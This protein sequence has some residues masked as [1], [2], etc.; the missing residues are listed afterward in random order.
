MSRMTAPE[1]LST[2]TVASARPRRARARRAPS[3]AKPPPMRTRR[4]R[5]PC[6]SAPRSSATVGRP[7]AC[8]A[9]Q[10][11]AAPTS[12]A[13]ATRASSSTGTSAAP[14]GCSLSA[15]S[16]RALGHAAA[17]APAAS[18]SAAGHEPDERGGQPVLAPP[19]RRAR[20]RSP[21]ARRSSEAVAARRRDAL[22]ASITPAAAS[23][24]SEKAT[25]SA[26]TTPAAESIS[27]RTPARV[28]KRTS[29]MPVL[30]ARACGQEHVDRLGVMGPDQ[31]LVD[32]E[33]G[34]RLAPQPGAGDVH[35]RGRGQREGDVVGRDGDPG[36]GDR[37]QPPDDQLVA[38]LQAPGARHAALDD[39]LVGA[40]VDVAP[41]DDRIAATPVD[42][43]DRGAIAR[44]AAAL[45]EDPVDLGAVGARRQVRQ[46]PD[47]GV[48]VGP[49]LGVEADDDIGQVGLRGPRGRSRSPAHSRR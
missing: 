3:A 40:P 30:V 23:A 22:A 14:G 6:N 10:A 45:H 28:R 25:S 24:T 9:G 16:S 43:L 32:S 41:L 44:A 48:D 7:V 27:T 42:E 2:A 12:A 36:D 20:R 38:D 17:S 35:V 47:H 1:T 26:M 33:L 39:R 18:P 21:A 13:I 29:S 37:S 46:A 31:R 34:A 4:D 19:P 49:A 11:A 15:S 8:Q 5:A